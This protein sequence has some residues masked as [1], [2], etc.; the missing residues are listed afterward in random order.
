MSTVTVIAICD[1]IDEAVDLANDSEYS[2]SAAV[3]TDNV[4]QA[5]D[6][7]SR[8]NSGQSSSLIHTIPPDI[9]IH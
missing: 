7:A 2:L 6:V 3:W 8:I 1:T 4:H 5:F 9:D